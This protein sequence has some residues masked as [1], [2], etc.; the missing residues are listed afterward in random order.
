MR[1]AQE[2]AAGGPRGHARGLSVLEV[3][4]DAW[5]NGGQ[6][7]QSARLKLE[8]G[9]THSQD[10]A[11]SGQGLQ[12]AKLQLKAGSTN[13]REAANSG[14]GPDRHGSSSKED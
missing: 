6:R 5:A 13:R 11:N 9:S 1:K 8:V 2:G 10:A 3:Q 12:S 4:E 14:Q 7:L